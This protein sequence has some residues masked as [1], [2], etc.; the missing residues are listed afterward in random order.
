MT[1][2]S[3]KFATK[4]SG[5]CRGFALCLA[6][7]LLTG[8]PQSA[9]AQ[10]GKAKQPQPAPVAKP[11]EK[12]KG[13]IIL[14]TGWVGPWLDDITRTG[15]GRMGKRLRAMGMRA[16]IADPANWDAVTTKFLR[17]SRRNEPIAVV[18]FSMGADAALS[19]ALK[20]QSEGLAVDNMV[21]I[22]GKE[23]LPISSNVRRATHFYI[24]GRPIRAG[25]NFSGKIRNVPIR[26]LSPKGG[27]VT[28]MTATA[29]RALHNAVIAE[30]LDGNQI[31]TDDT[32]AKAAE[33]KAAKRKADSGKSRRTAR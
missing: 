24:N 33:P 30:I 6:V 17:S 11:A 26:S 1:L 18:G 22:D 8:L 32:P 4:I 19:T 25:F 15:T 13:T 14:Y 21:L 7:A 3:E 5:I 9:Y 23:L 31:R 12:P 27:K 29:F 2:I 10:R 28:H 20:L 16:I